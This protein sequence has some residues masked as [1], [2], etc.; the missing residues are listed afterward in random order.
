MAKELDLR[1]LLELADK[2][3]APANRV[4]LASKATAAAVKAAREQTRAMQNQLGQVRDL[5]KMQ[6]ALGTTG[7]ELDAARRKLAELS[8]AQSS[9]G[10][11]SKKMARQIDL[12]RASVRKLSDKQD[13]L[14][15]HSSAART[16]LREQ[17][18]DTRHLTQAE[19][20]LGEQINRVNKRLA[21]QKTWLGRVS[22]AGDV[23]RGMLSRT[24]EVMKTGAAVGVAAG[25]AMLPFVKTA[26]QF[27]QY[28]AILET[29]DGSQAKAKQSMAWI[30]KFAVDTPF[31]LDQVTQAYVR[32]RAYGMD[33]TNGLL[34]TLGD[35]SAAMGKD[36][37]SAV[38]AIA[39]AITGENERLKEF[40]IKA[41]TKGN[42][43]TYTYTD[44]NGIQK[45]LQVMKN[46]RKAIEQGLRQIWD[47]KYAGAMER[48]SKTMGGLWS[49]LMDQWT[50]FQQMVMASGPFEKI[51]NQLS[52]LLDKINEM[53]ANGQL[54]ALA[55]K[56]GAQMV[57]LIDAA[58]IAAKKLWA[59]GVAAFD[60]A[61][62]VAGMVGGW[63]NLAIILI[64][65]KILP[66]VMML[67]KLG[68]VLWGLGATILPFVAKAAVWL[69]RAF[70]LN[71]IGLAITAIAGAAYLVITHWDTVK[72]ALGAVWGWIK[73]A[74]AALADFVSP[75]LVKIAPAQLITESWQAIKA[76]L[77]EIWGW[78]KAAGAEMAAG[79]KWA[80]LNMTPAG[81]VI[82]HW[83]Q[84]K[85][86]AGAVVDWLKSLP[87]QMMDIGRNI[88]DG[89]GRG[90][91]EKIQ[92]L[93]NKILGLADSLPDWMKRPLGIHSPSRVFAQIG[94]NTMAGLAMG[95]SR[96]SK[97]P[98]GSILQLND[99][100]KRTA[101]GITMV[102]AGASVGAM[103]AAA[104]A[105]TSG[106]IEI[107]QHIYAA[108]GQDAEAV[109]RG[110][111]QA[112]FDIINGKKAG[113]LYDAD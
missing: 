84:I 2:F 18:V 48:Q 87:A 27:E 14:K 20:S 3:S 83:E 107:I 40:G 31:E 43:I 4:S 106:K 93:K 17:G 11:Q 13:A 105:G 110:A 29:V 5:N 37:M 69:G 111:T 68:S 100:L 36:V 64:G 94:D 51:K 56:V 66:T 60:V 54:Q 96:S 16:A 23:A 92:G 1:V 88:I 21:S 38:E 70:M 46:D 72:S 99:K 108:P 33:P 109:G 42:T 44:K 28:Q 47:E 86:G 82:A 35:T 75:V 26:A 79:L 91:D 73:S 49:N 103:P 9:T 7:Q 59:L 71:P 102:A 45:Q 55:D 113:A 74:A 19:Q 101:A 80:L 89:I 65:L 77:G 67:G 81:Q 57:R 63:E 104:H 24:W 8:R 39:D 12:A 85:T 53:A 10:D 112:A 52:D 41:S 15:R 61:N 98:I 90:I 95:L 32:L 34:K 62:R 76:V 22:K 25:A 6:R 97:A 58:T 78:I 30:S 50:R